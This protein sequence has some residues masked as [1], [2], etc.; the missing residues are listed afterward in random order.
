MQHNAWNKSFVI[1]AHTAFN[2][3]AISDDGTEKGKSTSSFV[4]KDEKIV[5][6]C[7]I[8]ASEYAWPFC[9]LTFQ[10]HDPL[11]VENKFGIDLSN[12]DTASVFANYHN[13]ATHGI[14][15]QMR[16]FNPAY[17]NLKDDR[18]FKYNSVEYYL[19]G[20]TEKITIPLTSMQVASWWRYQQKLPMQYAAPE[21][22][23]IMVLEIA[24]GNGIKPGHYSIELEKIVFQGKRFSTE[25]VYIFLI[26][27]WICTTLFLSVYNL[28][29]RNKEI[30]DVKNKSTE[31]ARLNILLNAQSQK[32]QDKVDRD[33]LT[34]ALNRTGIK[35]LM[36]NEVPSLSIAF[37]DIDY[38][39]QVN[40]A[41]GH[42]AGDDILCEF[43]TLLTQHSRDSDFFARWGGEE[44]LL[45]CP[46][47]SLMQMQ[48]CTEVMRKVIENHQWPHGIE[49]TASFGLAERGDESIEEFISRADIALYKAKDQGR[50]K[51][52]ISNG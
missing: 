19:Y 42:A 1:D 36:A 12:F 40:D 52:V 48:A 17:S 43:T 16:S 18:T 14:R 21:L 45:L 38:F 3:L 11:S 37:I 6:S 15:F 29:L 28:T 26:S 8:I 49:L 9:E 7:E 33:P 20:P 50:N 41:L 25:N 39:K 31:L 5:L 46:N 24:T 47:T 27:L 4:I 30:K 35:A 22:K 51:V 2:I 44:F 13:L 23:N 32:L 34:G 10:L